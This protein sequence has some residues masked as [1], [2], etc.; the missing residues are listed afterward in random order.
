V[1][2]SVLTSSFVGDAFLIEQL[3]RPAV[4]LYRVSSLAADGRSA[5]SPVAFVRQKRMALKEDIRAF[6]DDSEREELFRIR[7]RRYMDVSGRY[8]VLDPDEERLGVLERR[9]G[10]SLVRS[11]WAVLDGEDEQEV[12]VAR[13][14]SMG[15][16]LARRVKDLIPMGDLV[17]I[18]YH[19]T[20]L[21]GERE[22]GEVRRSLGV[23]D[24]YVLDLGGDPDGVIDR[25][26]GVALAVAL[27]A[28]QAR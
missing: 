14:R 23:R 7:A 11:T 12:A 1:T 4:N 15:I 28:L 24:R 2:E 25:R 19:F 10:A 18:P 13:E 21:V 17:P 27:D 16:A 20:L 3:L 5:G 26:V 6:A 9:F 8:D 22:V